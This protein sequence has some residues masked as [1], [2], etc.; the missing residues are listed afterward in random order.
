VLAAGSVEHL[1]SPLPDRV[2]VAERDGLTWVFNYGAHAVETDLPAGDIV[3]GDAT[4]P[5]YDLTVFEG[6]TTDITVEES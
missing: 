1:D 6:A 2:Q 5:A 4:V 3:V